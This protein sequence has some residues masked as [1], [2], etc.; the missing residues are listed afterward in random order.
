VGAFLGWVMATLA[1]CVLLAGAWMFLAWRQA[2]EEAAAPVAALLGGLAQ[3]TGNLKDVNVDEVVQQVAA[4]LP[5]AEQDVPLAVT[6][7]VT[8]PDASVTPDAA[9]SNTAPPDAAVVRP[10]VRPDPTQPMAWYDDDGQAHITLP[11]AV[12]LKYRA[13]LGLD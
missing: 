1:A 11:E 8:P 9:V 7:A 12:P 3:V 4:N 2:Q 13:A 10:R 6:T 5:I